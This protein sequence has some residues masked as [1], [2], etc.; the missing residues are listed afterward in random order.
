MACILEIACV[1]FGIIILAKGRVPMGA[2]KEVRGAPAYL[3]GGLLIAVFPLA[4]G[5]GLVI[6]IRQAQ[7]GRPMNFG[8]IDWTMVAIEFG[9]IFACM[10]AAL[11]VALVSAKPKRRKKRRRVEDDDYDDYDDRPRKRWD[12]IEDEENNRR[13]DNDDEPRRR[14]SR[15]DADDDRRYRDY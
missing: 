11:V 3:V 7:Q 9:I 2:A 14:R 5:V 15:I 4:L 6:G 12:E 1:V 8:E 13:R 10:L